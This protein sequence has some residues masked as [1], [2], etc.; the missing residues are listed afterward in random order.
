M[1]TS[2]TLTRDQIIAA[3][4]LKIRV[5]GEGETPTS[6]QLSDSAAIL[7]SIVKSFDGAPGITFKRNTDKESGVAISAGGVSVS[8]ASTV[9]TVQGAH[10]VN[11]ATS[12]S[13][14]LTPMTRQEYIESGIDTTTPTQGVPTHYYVTNNKGT[15]KLFV[16]PSPS[17]NGTIVVWASHLLDIFDNA[18]DTGDFPSKFYLYLINELAHQLAYDN[19]LRLEEINLL[20]KQAD[21]ALARAISSEGEHIDGDITPLEKSPRSNTDGN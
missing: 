16:Y 5:I 14:P 19:G 8:L 6:S 18:S 12:A 4:L 20:E 13:Y 11:G 15:K 2:F 21:K 9:E 1:A 17:A 7:N 3:A 10:Y